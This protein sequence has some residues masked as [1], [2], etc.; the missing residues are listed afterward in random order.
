MRFIPYNPEQ[1]YLLPPSVRDVLGERHLCIFVHEVVERLDLSAFE[2]DYEEEG[3][4]A[5]APALL[6]KVW[7]Y[8]YALG[9]TSCRR[10]EQRVREDLGFRYLAGAAQPDFWTLNAFRQRHPQ[11]LNDLFT[12]V[13]ELARQAGLGRLGHVAID[14][15]RVKANASPDRVDSTKKLRAERAKIRRQIRRWQQACNAEAPNEAPGMELAEPER[16]RLQQ[17]LDQIPSRLKELK[18]SGLERRSRTDPDSRFLKT[19]QGFVLGYTVT[20]AASE[21]Q[22]IVEQRVTQEPTDSAALVPMVEGVKQRCGETPPQVSADS[23]FFALDPLQ[24]LEEQKVDVYVPD[25]NLARVLNR[26]GRLRGRAR[27]PVHRRMRQ[28][29][30]RPAGRAIYGRRKALIEPVFGVLKE[31]RGMRQFRRRGLE[32]VAVEMALAATAYNLTRMWNT[33]AA[34]A[35]AS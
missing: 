35:K 28:K 1:A 16:A 6:V 32:K 25:S 12:Q 29:L 10:L 33:A 24:E 31:Q 5:Y 11:A 17:Q 15:T 2:Q 4:P 19:R 7:L 30:R 13:V 18:K 8:A 9:V 21:D 34:G 20:L 23:G 27:H 14:S 3:R 26:G 22:L